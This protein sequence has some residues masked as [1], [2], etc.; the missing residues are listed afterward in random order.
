MSVYEAETARR[1]QASLPALPAE[2][3]ER[4]EALEGEGLARWR[5]LADELW[6]AATTL[7]ASQADA[8]LQAARSRIAALEGELSI[9][10]DNIEGADAKAADLQQ[11]LETEVALRTLA[12]TT[13]ETLRQDLRE[14]SALHAVQAADVERLVTELREQAERTG[15]QLAQAQAAAS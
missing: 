13:A 3:I 1:K 9:A 6:R 2:L 4:R 5:S 15:E 14:R 8:E 11:V 12:E 10:A 7:A